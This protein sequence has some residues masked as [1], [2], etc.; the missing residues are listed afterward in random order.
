M[1]AARLA[2]SSSSFRIDVVRESLGR[3]EAAARLELPDDA[4]LVAEAVVLD[5]LERDGVL[6]LLDSVV[7]SA[8]RQT[9]LLNVGHCPV[10]A[11]DVDDLSDFWRCL[12]G[13]THLLNGLDRTHRLT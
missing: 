2:G 8:A 3:R 9:L 12:R 5:G 13:A 4:E 6:K 10:G 1:N 11:A 7:L